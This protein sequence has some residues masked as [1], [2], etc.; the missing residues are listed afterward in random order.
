M[1]ANTLID[2]AR[3]LPVSQR[4]HLVAGIIQTIQ[5]EEDS[6]PIPAWVVDELERISIEHAANPASGST[7]EKFE[8]ELDKTVFRKG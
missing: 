4:R 1:N 5:A 2:E 6:E 8:T 3:K 7:L